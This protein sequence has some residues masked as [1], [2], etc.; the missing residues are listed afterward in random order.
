M[1][2]KVVQISE[3]KTPRILQTQQMI[4]KGRK[5]FWRHSKNFSKTPLFYFFHIL[6]KKFFFDFFFALKIIFWTKVTLSDHP[7]RPKKF[8]GLQIFL[9]NIFKIFF[10]NFLDKKFAFENFWWK[11]F[12]KMFFFDFCFFVLKIMFWIR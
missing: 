12:F 11:K 3:T 8:S 5:N 2:K 7:A 6:K 9:K 4:Q 1:V 10:E